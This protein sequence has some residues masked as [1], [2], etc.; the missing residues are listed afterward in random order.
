MA[1]RPYFLDLTQIRFPIGAVCSIGH[2]VSG[3]V[4]ALAAPLAVYLLAR[5]LDGPQ[6]YKQV[7]EWLAPFPVRAGLALLVWAFAHH[8]LAGTR[9]LL[10]DVDVGF[11]LAV[12]R[13][14]AWAVNLAGLGVALLAAAA[15]L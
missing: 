12:A 7:A 3:V 15:L 11:K 6:G 1:R 13:R 14:S 2:R 5:S 4:L 8:V 9:H 10:M